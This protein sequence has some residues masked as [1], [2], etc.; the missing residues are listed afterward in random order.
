VIKRLIGRS[1]DDRETQNDIKKLPYK[2][3]SVDNKPY[4]Q[5]TTNDGDKKYSPE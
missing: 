5:I 4:V 1:F 2:V 3:I